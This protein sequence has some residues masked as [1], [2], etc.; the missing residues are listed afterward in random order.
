M[1]VYSAFAKRRNPELPTISNRYVDYAEWGTGAVKF[2]S[3]GY[4][5]NLIG[6]PN[7]QHLFLY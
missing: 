2:R 5:K 4:G 3:V 1:K 6:W 7:L